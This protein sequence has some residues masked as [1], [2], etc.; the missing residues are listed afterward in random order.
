M[1]FLSE[2]STEVAN[3]LIHSGK[4]SFPEA[5]ANLFKKLVPADNVM[6]IA[7]PRR[8]LPQI[9]Y[10][11][12][13]PDNRRSTADKFIA[14]A[15]LLD[16]YYL[17]AT[18]HKKNG[19]Y[20]LHEIAPSGFKESEYFK[21][22]FTLTGLSDECG[23]LIQLEEVGRKFI[24][25]SIGQ[26]DT[27]EKFSEKNLQNL[28]A[29]SPLIEALVKSHWQNLEVEPET[30]LDLREQLE[31]A[32]TSF[33]TSILTERENQMVQMIL[34]GYSSKA[35]ADRFSISVET[36]KLHRKNAYAKL[37]L[38][39]QG[40]LFNL[41]INSLMNMENYEGGDPLVTYLSN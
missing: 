5:L 30:T 24:N 18:K 29:V 34:Q 22:Y 11:D 31:T 4:E 36:V 38:G 26:F 33:G 12:V 21:T 15:F 19:F 6:I 14:G 2:F 17:A 9:E 13:P 1:A 37:D 23:Y 25:I 41:F 27:V 28:A 3:V 35:I 10:N 8:K 40:E 7:Y 16:P 39:T 20:Y 32:L